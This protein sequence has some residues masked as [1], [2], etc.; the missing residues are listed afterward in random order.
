MFKHNIICIIYFTGLCQLIQDVFCDAD[1]DK[2]IS[3]M[4]YKGKYDTYCGSGQVLNGS[5]C[6]NVTECTKPVLYNRQCL[7]RC[8]DGYIYVTMDTKY[9]YDYSNPKKYYYTRADINEN[10][11]LDQTMIW[12]L[13]LSAVIANFVYILL[14]WLYLSTKQFSSKKLKSW[15]VHFCVRRPRDGERQRLINENS[16][17]G[18][19]FLRS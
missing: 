18:E 1:K 17:D 10:P 11:C 4:F 5:N 7:Q 14:V 13:I 3:I 8:P 19:G 6:I 15:F 16:D 2:E 12:L 9:N